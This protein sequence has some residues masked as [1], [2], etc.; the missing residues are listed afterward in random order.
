MADI[1]ISAQDHAVL[2]ESF[3]LLNQMNSD[4]VAKRALEQAIK[5]VRPEVE[6]EA[7]I[8]ERYAAPVRE[9]VTKLTAQFTEFMDSQ[10]KRDADAAERATNDTIAGQFADLAKEGYTVEGIEKIKT[11]MVDRKIADPEAA[12][13]LFDKLNPKPVQENPGWIPQA[14]DVDSTAGG[15]IDTKALFAN[16]ERWADAEVGKVLNEIRIGQAA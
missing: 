8:A 15:G 12:A 16:E 9:D 13:L 4:P 5:K 11:I 7:D 6:I 14:W 1:T 10:K 3:K 2:Q